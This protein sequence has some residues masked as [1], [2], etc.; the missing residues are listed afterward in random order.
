ME[1]VGDVFYNPEP[2]GVERPA[3][4]MV[5]YAPHSGH[6]AVPAKSSS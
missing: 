6:L 2:E 4:S 1:R 5:E 3:S